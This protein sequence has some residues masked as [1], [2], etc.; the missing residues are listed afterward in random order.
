MSMFSRACRP[1]KPD[2]RSAIRQLTDNAA[3]ENAGPARLFRAVSALF[4][5]NLLE[6]IVAFVIH[7]DKGREIFYFNFPD[8]FHAEFRI[9][10]ALQMLN[11]LLCQY[12]RRAAD[13]AQIKAAMFFYRH[14]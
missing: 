4:A 5:D 2:K 9:L 3:R 7:Q 14:P 8:S 10:D 6:E 13:T 11:A 1:D 12:R